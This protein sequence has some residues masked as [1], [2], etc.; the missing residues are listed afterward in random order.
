MKFTGFYQS[1]CKVVLSALLSAGI[2]AT[3]LS[4]QAAIDEPS[5]KP[6]SL[7]DGI[8]P[9]I[10]FTIDDSG[11][12]AWAYTPDSIS[13]YRDYRAS[14][15]NSFNAQYYNPAVKYQV[16]KK[17][18]YKNSQLI[19][20][21]YSTP[22]F[23]AAPTDGFSGSGKVDLSRHYVA[24]WYYEDQ[25]TGWLNC[26]DNCPSR[27]NQSRGGRSYKA[28]RAYYYD[29]TCSASPASSNNSC[30]SH[31]FVEGAEQEENFAI[32]YSFYRNRLLATKSAASIAFSKTSEDVR[33]VWG[34]LN[35][36][37]IGANSSSCGN[38]TF[39]Q[40]KGE[41]R[42]NFHKWLDALD[43]TGSTPSHRAMLRAGELMT[44]PSSYTRDANNK[45]YS[46][47]ASYHM[48]MTDGMWNQR[49]NSSA[50][51]G[52]AD[53]GKITQLP[54]GTAYDRNAGYARP[55]A[56]STNDTLADLAFHYWATDLLPDTDNDLKPRI[57]YPSSNKVGEYWDPRNDPSTWQN[58]VTFTVG[59]GLSNSLTRSDSPAWEGDHT[60]PTFAHID[61]LKALGSNGKSW[62]T[63]SDSNN[64]NVY[65]LWHAAI[66]SRGEFFSAD[67][68]ESMVQAFAKVLESISGRSTTA[69]SPA[70]N[71]GVDEDGTGYAYQASYAADQNWAGDL[72]AFKKSLNGDDEVIVTE[73][74]SAQALLNTQ[75]PNT[76]NIKMAKGSSLTD[77]TWSNLSSTQRGYLNKDPNPGGGADDLGSKRL[78]FLR[79]E[80]SNEG[81]LFRT[82]YAVLGDIVNSKPVSVRGARY[83][84]G[85]A[86][87]IEGQASGYHHYVTAH[88]SRTPMIYVG[89]ND[90]MLHAFNAS[91]GQETFAFVPSA[92]MPNLNKLT[93]LGYG[94][95]EHQFFVD[96][97]LA[98]ADV[99]IDNAW[100]TVLVGTLGAGG[101]GIF[102]LDITEPDSPVS[103]A[104]I[105][106]LWEFNS[107]RLEGSEVKLG[108]GYSKPTIARLH[109]GKWAV[110]M[111]NGYAADGSTNGKA[112]LLIIDM[113]TGELTDELIVQ[114]AQGVANGMSTPRLADVNADGLA[115]F[116]Y[117]GDLQG[118]VWRFDLARAGS[119]SHPNDPFKRT[120]EPRQGE[121][122]AFQVSFGGKPLF[123]AVDKDGSRQPI[124]AA[125]SIIR[126]PTNNGY[127]IAVGT[128]RYYTEGDKG[129]VSGSKQS[130]YGIWDPTTKEPRSSSKSGFPFTTVTRSKLQ[131]QI[132]GAEDVPLESNSLIKDTGARVLSNYAVNWAAKKGDSWV[133]TSNSKVG[134][135]FDLP[136]EKEMIVA[137][138]LQFGRTLYFQTLIPNADPC[139][140]GVDNWTYAINPA[141]GG[142][143]LHH[144]WTDYRKKDDSGQ[145]ITAVKM[146]GE[147]G[148]SIGQRADKK[149][150]LCTGGMCNTITPDPA[151]LG[152]QS[153]R[154][155]EEQ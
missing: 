90:G 94:G 78:A 7:I 70:M 26:I 99:F 132:M 83:L 84:A 100:R 106:L 152:R 80:R 45:P 18:T 125:P 56:D 76:R 118:N 12:M 131:E 29:Y 41:H 124:M 54:D 146:D 104:G 142:R 148:I 13:G 97:S 119:S 145:V 42:E 60:N 147:G 46:C 114:G 120:M 5:Q 93:S 28:S 58:L 98:V 129:G 81:K 74:W 66:N 61:E 92:V 107:D 155:V 91:T 69:S 37:H 122:V 14:R 15:S 57:L 23:T 88:A 135:Y 2:L 71:S 24:Q 52:N 68:P 130:I 127:I 139:A 25:S 3:S 112:S 38:N 17:V 73:Q 48:F 39:G 87:S 21:D 19:T 109:N 126:H 121:S 8:L 102:A 40:F 115:D 44:K 86:N 149:H 34:A 11:S 31:R 138:M 77:F 103:G 143:T 20:E 65:D 33:M 105:K 150:E 123:T 140:S 111:G 30:Y 141:T 55:Y 72:K 27:N 1:A 50:L 53:Y 62:P 82:R 63:V 49:P 116:A 59:L 133:I 128:G 101:K 75:S 153:W 110:V 85:P 154:E 117:A 67:S 47:Q 35:S 43:W 95:A 96:G 10:L 144:A 151:S 136:L 108:Y 9:N 51:K 32:W 79:G 89:A 4:A 134:W 6:L 64:N 137:D 113:E 16:P 36:C 22:S